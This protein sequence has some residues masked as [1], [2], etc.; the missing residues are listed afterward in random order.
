MTQSRWDRTLATLARLPLLGFL[1]CVLSAGMF[2]LCNVIVKKVE[3][4]DPF[5]IAFYRFVGILLPSLPIVIYRQE[6]RRTC[7]EN[8]VNIYCAQDPFPKESRLLLIVRSVFGASNLLIIFYGLKHMPMADVNMISAGSPIWVVIFARIFLKEPLKVFD[9][10]N[11]FVTLLGILFI[12][13]SFQ[14]YQSIINNVTKPQCVFRPPFIFG[15]DSSYVVD[16]QYYVA[17][18]INFVG[19]ILLQSNVYII[20]RKLKHIHFSVTLMVFGGVGQCCNEYSNYSNIRMFPFL[21]ISL[22]FYIDLIINK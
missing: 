19:A 15:Y 5:T 22:N 12:I 4:V 16:P 3:A 7:E 13:R 1:L 9:I 14:D 20:L 2:G 8:S 17:A 6:V 11:V 18:A 10:I 21:I